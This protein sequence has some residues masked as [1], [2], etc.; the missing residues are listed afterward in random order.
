MNG[1]SGYSGPNGVN[2][3][4]MPSGPNG[5]NGPNGSAAELD[6][7]GFSGFSGFSGPSGGFLDL[8]GGAFPLDPLESFY[9]TQPLDTSE[10]NSSYLQAIQQERENLQQIDTLLLSG[11]RSPRDSHL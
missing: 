11:V 9:S 5:P 7:P 10:S 8:E 3:S 1:I 4:S 6:F 2:A